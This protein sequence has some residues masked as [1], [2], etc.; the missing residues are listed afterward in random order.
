MPQSQDRVVAD[1]RLFPSDANC[2]LTIAGT[3][4]EVLAVAV[5]HAVSEHGHTD[6]P[7]LRQQLRGMLRPEMADRPTEARR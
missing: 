4:D 1:C 5:R 6:S 3:E 7:E 2:S